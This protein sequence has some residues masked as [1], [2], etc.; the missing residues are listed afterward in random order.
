[1]T[2]TRLDGTRS[3]TDTHTIQRRGLKCRD[4]APDRKAAPHTG[5]YARPASCMLHHTRPAIPGAPSTDAT[6]RTLAPPEAR[7]AAALS[8]ARAIRALPPSASPPPRP[9]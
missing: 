1:M 7:P 4:V 5:H 8:S 2:Y 9:R 3:Q 6:T